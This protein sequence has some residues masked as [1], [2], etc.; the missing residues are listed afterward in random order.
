MSI[1]K[2]VGIETEYGIFVWGAPEFNP[3]HPS[4]LML[5]AYQMIGGP[6][7]PMG[8]YYNVQTGSVVVQ[9]PQ[10]VKMAADS[11]GEQAL[12]DAIDAAVDF[13]EEEIVELDEV[14]TTSTA[15]VLYGL[16]SLMLANGARYYIDHAHPEY[17]TPETLSPRLVVAADKA[18]E[19]IVARCMVAVNT[20][21]MLPEGQRVAI[22]KNNSDQKGNSYGCHENYL[23]SMALFEDLLKL[24]SHLIFRYLLP[25]LVTRTVF[26]GAG[27]VGSENHT[28]PATF[29]LAQRADFFEMLI[30]L[31]TTYRRPLFNTRDEAHT[32]SGT[33]RRLHVILGDANMAELATYL[34]VGTTQLLLHMIEDDF[35]KTDLTLKDP[36]AA[37]KQ[38]S[39]DLTFRAPL[40]LENGQQ[41]TAVEVQEVYLDLAEKYLEERGGTDEQWAVWE[42]WAEVIDTLQTDNR[43]ALTRKLDWA[44]KKQV[45]DRYVASQG[46][47]WEDVAQWQPV[48]E[49]AVKVGTPQLATALVENAG[50]PLAE[51]EK[52]REVYFTLRRLDLEYHDV[53]YAGANA[54]LFYRLQNGGHVERLLTEEE[55]EARIQ[56][57]PPDTRAWLRGKVVEKF[58]AHIIGAD[59]SYL[60]LRYAGTNANTIYQLEFPNPLLGTQQDL[61]DVWDQLTTPEEMFAHF[62]T[63]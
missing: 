30:G 29:Q 51:Y 37:F 57:P 46:T 13:G 21:G 42:A 16:G 34:K 40:E 41:M 43:Q 52:Q 6:S 55:V 5:N 39:R 31:Q 48:I 23:L 60:R 44:I 50:L 38:V 35:L 36:L 10:T 49:K 61:A 28:A 20:N 18:G 25:F 58:S 53:H 17:C 19:R 1:P 9:Q 8:L 59:W 2:A 32:D 12:R 27:K 56:E 54:G 62:L 33:F 11:A 22:Y 7:I 14:G 3:F 26:T 4:R 45:L 63:G 24:R 15:T 47:T